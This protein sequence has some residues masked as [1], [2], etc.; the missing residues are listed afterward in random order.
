MVVINNIHAVITLQSYRNLIRCAVTY[1]FITFWFC[2]QQSEESHGC[3]TGIN[4]CVQH[5]CIHV[6]VEYQ[7]NYL[8]FSHLTHS[9][10]FCEK[11]K[12]ILVGG[13]DY[14]WCWKR[15]NLLIFKWE[16]VLCRSI[17]YVRCGMMW[18]NVDD[19]RQVYAHF[20]DVGLQNR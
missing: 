15:E 12:E 3:W 1:Y 11:N 18:I 8:Y 2:I 13:K 7:E 20:Y 5:T 19:G 9:S 16:L 14:I 17:V 4:T 10:R 6:H